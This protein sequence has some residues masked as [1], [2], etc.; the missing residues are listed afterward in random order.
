[1]RLVRL[2]AWLCALCLLVGCTAPTNTPA[3]AP[4]PDDAATAKT[5]AVPLAE[6][7]CRMDFATLAAHSAID[8]E[9]QGAIVDYMGLRDENGKICWKNR[10]FD[11]FAEYVAYVD[12][13]TAAFFSD[14]E[15]TVN[16]ATVYESDKLEAVFD[17]AKTAEYRGYDLDPAIPA[18]YDAALDARNADRGAIVEIVV[19]TVDAGYVIQVCLLKIDSEWK[20]ISPTVI[21]LLGSGA[22]GP[23]YRYLRKIVQ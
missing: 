2:A 8:V 1:M 11:D 14:F 16:R 12:G 19:D 17:Q 4:K 21:G 22:E 5:A 6:A 15:L 23:T 20:S 18:R 13:Q 10:A 3:P 7:V 9:T